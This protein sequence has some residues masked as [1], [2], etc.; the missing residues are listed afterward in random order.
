[1]LDSQAAQFVAAKGPPEADEQQ[2]PVPPTAQQARVVPCDSGRL[3]LP[4]QPGHALLQL[5]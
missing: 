2:G 1:M 3:P 5:A 4:L